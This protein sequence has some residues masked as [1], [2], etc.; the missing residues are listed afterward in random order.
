MTASP[1]QLMLRVWYG[2]KKG[3]AAKKRLKAWLWTKPVPSSA[4]DE[5]YVESKVRRWDAASAGRVH[6]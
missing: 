5:F 3:R 1:S 2:G 4:Y 6:R